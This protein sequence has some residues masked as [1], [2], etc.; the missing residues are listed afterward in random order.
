[1]ASNEIRKPDLEELGGD[2]A[3]Q[4]EDLE[5]LTREK[6][7]DTLSSIE[8][9][10]SS[11]DAAKKKPAGLKERVQRLKKIKAALEEWERESLQSARMKDLWA[12]VERL[13]KFTEICDSFA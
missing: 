8:V 13:R 6:V 1:M 9:A 2:Y 10:V 12:R 4:I 5:K 3:E 7:S 11:Y